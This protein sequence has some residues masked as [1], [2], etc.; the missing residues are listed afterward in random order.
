MSPSK[1]EAVV[2]FM[3]GKQVQHQ[4]G[5]KWLNVTSFYQFDHFHIFRIKP[6]REELVRQMFVHPFP[7]L[8]QAYKNP[9]LRLEFDATTHKLIK[10][11]ILTYEPMQPNS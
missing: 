5:E 7:K 11:E 4:A 9:N 1:H 2:A 3:A 8:E 10:A 6:E